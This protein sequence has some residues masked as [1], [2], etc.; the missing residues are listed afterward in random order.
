MSLRPRASP[1]QTV[2]SAPPSE[3]DPSL[4]DTFILLQGF[5]TSASTEKACALELNPCILQRVA[6]RT[7]RVSVRTLSLREIPRS[8]CINPGWITSS[9]GWQ[10]L[11]EALFSPSGSVTLRN[12]CVAMCSPRR[13]PV[14]NIW[15]LARLSSSPQCFSHSAF[16]PLQ[17]VSFAL[18]P[19][20]SV[21]G[22]PCGKGEE[23]GP[24]QTKF[25]LSW[26]NNPKLNYKEIPRGG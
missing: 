8:V 24:R 20:E 26:N 16:H 13:A 10:H 14:Q 4:S 3:L 19:T 7:S 5:P 17:R 11:R 23:T 6:G 18:S 12:W 21:D 22:S 25:C 15:L 9:N 2:P 1:V